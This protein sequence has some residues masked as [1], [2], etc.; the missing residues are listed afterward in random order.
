[1]TLPELMQ[2]LVDN[3]RYLRD[4]FQKA[5]EVTDKENDQP[6][7]DM[8]NGFKIDVDKKIW[9]LNAYLDKGPFDGE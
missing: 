3:F 2:R 5:I 6:T 8:I 7:Q 9:M 4:Q 1:Y